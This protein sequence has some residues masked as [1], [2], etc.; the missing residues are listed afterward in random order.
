ML[1]WARGGQVGAVEAWVV[2]RGGD[3]RR[4]GGVTRGP[5]ADDAD[6]P[7]V[8]RLHLGARAN[9]S[10]SRPVG[11]IRLQESDADRLSRDPFHAGHLALV[12]LR[13]DAP[14]DGGEQLS[15]IPI[16]APTRPY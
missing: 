5:R 12:L 2:V 16:S 6:A 9:V 1:G 15:L 7:P 11:E 4:R 14:G 10:L 13:A 3:A 8:L